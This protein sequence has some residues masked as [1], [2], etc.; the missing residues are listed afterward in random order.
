MKISS[1][2]LPDPVEFCKICFVVVEG[3]KNFYKCKLCGAQVKCT[4]GYSSTKRHVLTKHKDNW[5]DIFP[6]NNDDN[7]QNSIKSF[8]PSL[9]SISQ[10]AKRDYQWLS[11]IVMTDQ[12]FSIVEN[13]HCRAL[14][15]YGPI[16]RPY[17]MKKLKEVHEQVQLTLTTSVPERFGV[18]MDGNSI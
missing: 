8:Y 12:P 3:L 1:D 2:G 5:R 11:F 4:A 10:E 18:I 13:S 14:S 7:Q 16:T 6:S 9:L 17:L 15:K